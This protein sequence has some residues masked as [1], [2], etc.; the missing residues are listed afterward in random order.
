[1]TLLPLLRQRFF[2]QNGDPLSGGLLYSYVANTATPKATYTDS[3]GAT[4]NTNPIVLDS[5]GYCDV[6]V[7]AGAYKFVLTDADDAEIWSRDNIVASLDETETPW[8]TY[9]ILDGQ[10]ATDLVGETMDLSKY[11]S[12]VFSVEIIRGTTV[13][14]N[15]SL[16]IQNVND[17][18]R[19]SVGPYN[20]DQA[21]GVTFSISQT[22]DI[23]QLR[24]ACSEGPGD[25]TIKISHSFVPV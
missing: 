1:V 23:V 10:S 13:F 5:D 17:T 24:A 7:G 9:T 20:T 2:D 15:G 11:S 6:W 19:V 16:A 22:D 12:G 25:G 3:S 14:A 21:T 8:I 4:P 18:P